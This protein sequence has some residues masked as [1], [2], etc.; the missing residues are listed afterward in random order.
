MSISSVF[1]EDYCRFRLSM[2]CGSGEEARGNEKPEKP[3][4]KKVYHTPTPFFYGSPYDTSGEARREFRNYR[5]FMMSQ[6][7]QML[8]DSGVIIM[9]S[10]R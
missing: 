2:G 5:L 6:M 7:P 1:G 9:L 8:Q 10:S 3:I 4:R